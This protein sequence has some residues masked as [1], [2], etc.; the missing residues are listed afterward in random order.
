[1]KAI[2]KITNPVTLINSILQYHIIII[3]SIDDKKIIKFP[4]LSH[5]IQLIN[6]QRPIDIVWYYLIYYIVF[7][8]P[9][10]I[11][12][13]FAKPLGAKNLLQRI[14]VVVT[15]L[16][17]TEKEIKELQKLVGKRIALKIS[18]W[19]ANYHQVGDFHTDSIM[20]GEH[21]DELPIDGVKDPLVFIIGVLT[22]P[23]EPMISQPE[24]E[25][26]VNNDMVNVVKNLI[27]LEI[28]R[29]DKNEF[30]ALFGDER[31][32][33][34]L[35]EFLPMIYEPLFAIYAKGDTGMLLS[36][37]FKLAKSSLATAEA[38]QKALQDPSQSVC[39]A[40]DNNLVHFL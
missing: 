38:T 13:F 37:L 35:K 39:E 25:H 23:L 14:F 36:A 3:I 29:K 21:E 17:R 1:M 19:I 4:L 31:V 24:I 16:S 11:H 26:I 5:S 28:R 10:M 22:H 7:I 15:E 20:P 27:A 2:L 12:L 9:Y 33:S 8:L 6:V 34:L 30:I 18:Q 32:I 40:C